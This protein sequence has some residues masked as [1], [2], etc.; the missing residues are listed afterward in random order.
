MTKPSRRLPPQP[1]RCGESDPSKFYYV[2]KTKYNPD[3]SV[4][5]YA[6]TRRQP[7]KACQLEVTNRARR[8]RL[9]AP[10]RTIA[11]ILRK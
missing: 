5:S 3:G 8:A 2:T 1:C 4:N 7:C 11:D 9:P 6:G 10:P